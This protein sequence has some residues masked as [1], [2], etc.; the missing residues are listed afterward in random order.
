MWTL[1][2]PV[3]DFSGGQANAVGAVDSRAKIWTAGEM[4]DEG[5]DY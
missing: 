2:G 3:G 1:S 4:T 5:I